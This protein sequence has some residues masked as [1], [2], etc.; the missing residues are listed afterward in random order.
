LG[1]ISPLLKASSQSCLPTRNSPNRRMGRSESRE[2]RNQRTSRDPEHS[3]TRF[4]ARS[5]QMD[6]ARN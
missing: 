4:E 3:N 5:C 6:R 2:G 1:H